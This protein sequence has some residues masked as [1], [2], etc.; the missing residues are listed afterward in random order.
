M[1]NLP[2]RANIM[3]VNPVWGSEDLARPPQPAFGQPQKVGNA[4]QIR[5]SLRLQW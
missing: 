4:R 3:A 2:N 1:F 5:L